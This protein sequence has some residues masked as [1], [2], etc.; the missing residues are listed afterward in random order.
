MAEQSQGSA[1]QGAGG[2]ALSARADEDLP[3]PPRGASLACQGGRC[4]A[5]A[6]HPPHP[7]ITCMPKPLANLAQ[8]VVGGKLY[9]LVCQGGRGFL[10][11]PTSSQ[12]STRP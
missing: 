10:A 7:S 1:R 2:Q 11:R 8:V 5:R 9:I 4:R 12:G 6:R 3:S